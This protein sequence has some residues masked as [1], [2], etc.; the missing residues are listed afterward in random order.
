MRNKYKFTFDAAELMTPRL[1]QIERCAAFDESAWCGFLLSES[2]ALL[3]LQYV[4]ACCSLDGYR[5]IRKQD[6]VRVSDDF[7][8]RDFVERA[9]RCKDLHSSEPSINLNDD[10]ERLMCDIA[11]EYG[12]VSIHRELVCPDECEIGKIRVADSETYILDWITP[13][14]EWSRDD[15]PFRFAEITRLDFDDEYGQTLLI[16]NAD[17]NGR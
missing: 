6:V 15:R 12:L 9:L 7:A 10:L 3:L 8:K 5:C 17:R 2:Q 16:V 11:M 1:V 4:S 14:A 13:N